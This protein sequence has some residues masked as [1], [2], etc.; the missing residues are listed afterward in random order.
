MAF[1][2]RKKHARSSG[3][4]RS[5]TPVFDRAAKPSLVW[6][7]VKFCA[8]PALAFGALLYFG[9]PA[10]RVQYSY[11]GSYTSPT[12]HQC[13]YRTL[14]RWHDVHPTW[15]ECP[16]VIFVPVHITDFLGGAS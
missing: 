1:P 4:M 14:R 9:E 2:G 10:L 15:G 16:L 8:V 6:G 3:R 5:T 12:Y 7:T 11:T 13:L